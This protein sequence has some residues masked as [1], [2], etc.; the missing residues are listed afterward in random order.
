MHAETALTAAR[1]SRNRAKITNDPCKLFGH[2]GRKRE[3][4]R[5]RD[6]V[7]IYLDA[8]GSRD[9]VTPFQLVGIRRAAELTYAAEVMRARFVSGDV[10]ADPEMLVKLE[11]E[12]RRAE[13]TL[14][15]KGTSR[16]PPTLAEHLASRAAMAA[17]ETS[18]A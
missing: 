3:G 18:V 14:G 15:I 1:L 10:T 11:G 4:R 16:R 8:L 2:D 12:A 17:D 7:S 6:L 5:R 9:A 13:R